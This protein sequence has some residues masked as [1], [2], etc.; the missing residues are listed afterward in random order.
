MFLQTLKNPLPEADVGKVEENPFSIEVGYEGPW[1]PLGRAVAESPGV[2]AVTGP[3]VREDLSPTPTQVWVLSETR[4]FGPQAG[5]LCC[6][7]APQG[8]WGLSAPVRDT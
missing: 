7:A 5:R 1:Q 8:P 3:L 2:P 6:V 4:A